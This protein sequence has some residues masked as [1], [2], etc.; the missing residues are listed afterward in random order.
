MKEFQQKQKT[1]R[2]LYSLPVLAVLSIL[3]IFMI[4]GVVEVV[5]IRQTSVID[6]NRLQEKVSV[7]SDRERELEGGIE[8]LKTEAGINEEIKEKFNVTQSDEQVAIIVDAKK[9]TSTEDISLDVWYKKVWHKIIN[10][11]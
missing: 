11:W 9:A 10:L 6:V 4:R 1:R 2:R 7:L 5:Q 8:R 3:T